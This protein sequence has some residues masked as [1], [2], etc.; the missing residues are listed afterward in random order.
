MEI[1][2]S[3]EASEAKVEDSVTQ[4]TGSGPISLKHIS[5]PDPVVYKLV[6]VDGEGRLVPATDDEVLVVEDLLKDEKP[7]HFGADSGDPT[8]CIK[9]EGHPMEKIHFLSSEEKILA[10]SLRSENL[11][12]DAEDTSAQFDAGVDL[13]EKNVHPEETVRHLASPFDTNNINQSLNVV[14]CSESLGGSIE[15]GSSNSDVATSWKPDFSKLKGEICLDDL[16]VKELQET[17]RATF[18]RETSVKDKQWLKRRISMGLTNSCDFSTMTF[19]IKDNEVVK[20]GKKE[21]RKSSA[22]HKDFAV[23]VVNETS[24][25]PLDGIHEPKESNP[26]FDDKNAQN[27]VLEHDSVREDPGSEQRAAKRVR[28]PTKRYIEEISEV[29]SRNTSGRLVPMVKSSEHGQPYSKDFIRPL[30]NVQSIGRPM[31]TRQDSLGGS[32]VKVPYVSRVRR[33]RPRENF[34]P[35]MKLQHNGIGLATRMVKR[36]LGEP[37]P[38]P[39]DETQNEVPKLSLSPGWIQQPVIAA[40]EK[41]NQY[42]ERKEVVL[43]KNVELKRMDSFEDSSDDNMG[44]VPAPSGGMRRKHHRPW[45]LTE[46]VKLV[47]GVARYGA[48]RWS[49]IK[50]LAFASYS[51]RTSVDLKDKWRNLLRA[52]F[53]QLPAEKGMQNVRK[54]ASIPIPAPILLRVRELAQ[55]QAQVPPTLGSSKFAGHSGDSDRSV[56][57]ARSGYL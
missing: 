20:K 25:G 35:L 27:P 45:S 5:D 13:G 21:N 36:A 39:E 56:H 15:H 14:G 12:A 44:N 41:G 53:S 16:T 37:G 9:T 29:E 4:E 40:S 55:M 28:K 30:Q 52:S 31:V 6:R 17:F 3:L 43:G 32:G 10:G 49:E 48:G 22:V 1:V 34:M 51:Y 26:D 46:V 2:V 33:G 18:G 38:P 24:G 42:L 47:E 54:H 50:R 19:V 57:E 8:E 11:Q 7:Q 23:G